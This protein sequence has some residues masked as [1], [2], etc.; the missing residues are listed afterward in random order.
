MASENI[1]RQ[2]ILAAVDRLVA[3]HND[4]EDAH[5]TWR[6]MPRNLQREGAAPPDRI[7][8]N[9]DAGQAVED[10]A[11][12][13]E[14][15]TAPLDCQELVVAIGRFLVHWDRYTK[16]VEQTPTGEPQPV[17]WSAYREILEKRRGSA[18][19]S[20]TP[21]E[22]VHA[23]LAANVPA[24]TIAKIYEDGR[25]PETFGG[26]AVHYGPFFDSLGRPDHVLIQ[27]QAKAELAG[28]IEEMVVPPGWQSEEDERM[29]ASRRRMM[30][31]RLNKVKLAAADRERDDETQGGGGYEDPATIEQLILEGAFESQ[32]A[33][34][35]NVSVAEV[36]AVAAKMGHEINTPSD[37]QV[38]W[39]QKQKELAE[40][41][42]ASAA[43]TEKA[44]GDLVREQIVDLW[45][46]NQDQS[47]SEIVD[48][49]MKQHAVNVSPQKVSAILRE[50]RK[51]RKQ[52]AEVF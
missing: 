2:R 13:V 50:Y 23:L 16:Q 41:E 21:K 6:R 25:R 37:D 45:A 30:E 28:N 17:L 44:E 32:I 27:Q 33:K 26:D 8:D 24:L 38:T 10:L 31:R 47:A 20:T 19:P 49:M 52:S 39:E 5:E 42:A 43:E 4:W 51:T 1:A 36:R 18:A 7:R 3:V 14:D 29:A 40:I 22:P 9:L 15:V 35:K 12:V 46:G 34:V 11:M 48:E